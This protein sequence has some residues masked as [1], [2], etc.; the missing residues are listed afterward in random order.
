MAL[1]LPDSGTTSAT[2]GRRSPPSALRNADAIL[3]VLRAHAPTTGRM[4]EIAAGSG[5]HSARFAAALPGLDWQPTDVDVAHFTSITA[6]C[7]DLPSI[8]QPALLDATQP[9][10]SVLWPQRDAIL[11]VNLLHLIPAP[12]AETLLAEVALALAPQGTAFLYGPFL[13]D[14]VATSQGDAAFHASLTDQDPRIGYKDI[15]W[16]QTLLH[17]AGLATRILPMP[18]NNLMILARHP[19]P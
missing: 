19:A 17:Q 10:W 4:L 18:A 1:T 11:L 3:E 16:V 2:D 9:G 12:A 6:W 15:A 5:L 13:R 8:R 7:A 14:G